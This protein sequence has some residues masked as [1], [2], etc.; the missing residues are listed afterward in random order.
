MMTH[1]PKYT[2]R[3][4]K[5]TVSLINILT[6]FEEGT[7]NHDSC[8][9]FALS[10]FFYNRFLGVD[11]HKV[12]QQIK[13][14]CEKFI[15]YSQPAKSQG[16]K[17]LS[18]DF[19]SRDLTGTC[20]SH[21]QAH[22][23]ILS[24]LL[25][26]AGQPVHKPYVRKAKQAPTK[27][28]V[29]FDWASYLLE[30]EDEPKMWVWEL[31][32]LPSDDEENIVQADDTQN[33]ESSATV[34]IINA[35]SSGA[36]ESVEVALVQPYWKAQITPLDQQKLLFNLSTLKAPN[37][38][39]CP[40]GNI[41]EYHVLREIV[42]FLC[43][44]K[45]LHV[46]HN[47]NGKQIVRENLQLC[48]Q[49]QKSLEQGILFYAKC[50]DDVAKLKAFAFSSKNQDSLTYEAFASSLLAYFK[51]ME[52]DLLRIE[53][54]L[55]SVKETILLGDLNEMIKL[56]VQAIGVLSRVFNLSVGSHQK[57]ESCAYRTSRLLS[58]LYTAVVDEI[59]LHDTSSTDKVQ[60]A[61]VLVFIWLCTI[62]PYL[63]IV[64]RWVGS[65]ELQDPKGE[66]VIQR[67]P[68]VT[69]CEDA[70]FWKDAVLDVVECSEKFLPWLQPFLP[71]IIRGGK[72]MEIIKTLFVISQKKFA[73]NNDFIRDKL[74]ERFTSIFRCLLSGSSVPQDSVNYFES[75]PSD[76]YIHETSSD[77]LLN[78]NFQMLFSGKGLKLPEL[79]KIR[80]L[81]HSSRPF[82]LLVHKSLQP[83]IDLRCSYASVK[84]LDILKTH[85][86]LSEV[87]E[88]FQNL[89]LMLWG[90]VLHSF[91]VG[92]FHHIEVNGGIECDL[93]GLNILLHDAIAEKVDQ[94]VPVYVA[95][96]DTSVS[97]NTSY[98]PLPRSSEKSSVDSS[99]LLLS[100]T[101]NVTL[102]STVDWP[103]NLVLSEE[104]VATYQL[105]FSYLM[106]LK[107]AVYSL[108]S[109][110]F[111][112][113][114]QRSGFGPSIK[115]D[116]TVSE[117][118][119]RLSILRSKV[120]HLL[121]H[122]QS[123]VMTSV[124]HAQ[125][126]IFAEKLDQAANLDDVIVAHETFLRKVKCFCLLDNEKQTE[127]LIQG[128]L[129][130]VMVLA[131]TLNL[132]WRQGVGYIHS[133]N[134]MKHESD[135]RDSSEFLQ[136]IL[137]TVANR[138]AVPLLT[139]LAYS[140]LPA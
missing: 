11:D 111:S 37:T 117:K 99:Q 48:H 15:I 122:W 75:L 16:F 41:E 10:N 133:R 103:T 45:Q 57:S 70:N 84:L 56:H 8:T 62:R 35:V 108:E 43:G 38:K 123:F 87:L 95:L 115:D 20:F 36:S 104:A 101:D 61:D 112:S 82:P 120:L 44:W 127:K 135:F 89:Y 22:Y 126:Q 74:Y 28:D 65:G 63:D 80:K 69:K 90:D 4:K 58:V 42:W 24:L 60:I 17:S 31:S 64:D 113:V 77:S 137:K 23:R 134:V 92:L 21:S 106:Q 125:Q 49:T 1:N 116:V 85:C 18:E 51:W 129:K 86:G 76:T 32:P 34:S 19:L 30:G 94:S 97:Y 98:G 66:F 72:S 119:H 88:T 14:L 50:G 110:K 55:V 83:C 130:K 93:V 68:M 46:F 107:R 73:E 6:E 12:K 138:G 139:S 132:L 2:R 140:M 131:I 96:K 67:Q 47:H 114:Y 9:E 102:Q 3:V 128:T 39:S 53:K 109:L 54:A 100:M 81:C 79:L 13:G 52:T 40:L 105:I 25:S 7:E 121:R 26:L 71:A 136:R 118:A 5:L 91:C 78:A 29:S 27:Q 59:Q 33:L 124:I